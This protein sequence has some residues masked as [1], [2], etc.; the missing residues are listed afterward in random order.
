MKLLV[1]VAF[2]FASIDASSQQ[3]FSKLDVGKLRVLSTTASSIPC[4][5]MTEVQ[6]DAISSP[7]NGSCVYNTT[8]SSLNVYNGSLWGS[9]GGGLSLWQTGFVYAVGDVVINSN[10]IYRANTAHTSGGTFAGD[11]AN[12]DQL[13]HNV[14]DAT[15]TLPIGNGGTNSSTALS[16]SSIMI[17]NG[18]QVVQGAAGTSNTVLHGNASGAPSYSAVSLTADVSGVL[19]M[20]NG[21]TNKNMTASAGSVAYSDA[22]SLELTSVGTS[23]QVLVSN[24][25]SAPSW[26]PFSVTGVVYSSGATGVD[27]QSFR[28]GSGATCNA[29]C[30]S[31][32]TICN[33]IGT[34]LTSV[35]RQSTG[36]YRFNGIDGTKYNC[37]G[38]GI[39]GADLGIFF[40]EINN[41]TSSYVQATI[42]NSG[43]SLGNA[44]MMVNCVGIP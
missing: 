28:F 25:T 15:G 36:V 7:A 4:P 23:G 2:L 17:S 35:T 22:D 10:K 41:S 27:I 3:T 32:C 9:V 43:G 37:N 12:W 6:R 14:S 18:T 29:E 5:A 16:G 30:S 44:Y 34:K 24:G 11:L 21:G 13:A 19:P 33:Q 20:A 31:T 42:T 8:T 40:H 1:I 26:S 39:A 38:T